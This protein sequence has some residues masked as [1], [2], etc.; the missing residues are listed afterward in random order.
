MFMGIFWVNKW[1]YLSGP[2]SLILESGWTLNWPKVHRV[3]AVARQ[4]P[5]PQKAAS[6]INPV[7]N[8][9]SGRDRWNS[10]P[11]L[12]RQVLPE[13]HSMSFHRGLTLGF[14]TVLVWVCEEGESL[15]HLISQWLPYRSGWFCSPLS[16]RSIW[17]KY[18]VGLRVGIEDLRGRSQVVIILLLNC[19]FFFLLRLLILKKKLSQWESLEMETPTYSSSR[20][21]FLTLCHIGFIITAMIVVIVLNHFRL[22]HRHWDLSPLNDFPKKRRTCSP[23]FIVQ[24]STQLT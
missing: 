1:I 3:L 21:Q 23:V 19:L 20:H 14:V 5:L 4:P 24:F 11:W 2:N 9:L 18:P 8:I 10:Q 17:S 6:L 15:L 22:M 13:N 7:R 12:R 16:G